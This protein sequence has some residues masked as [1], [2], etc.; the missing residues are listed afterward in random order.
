M[1][2]ILILGKSADISGNRTAM[3]LENKCTS[4]GTLGDLAGHSVIRANKTHVLL[5]CH[6]ENALVQG[7]LFL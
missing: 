5:V 4:A 6:I 1:N 7:N 3:K 2:V